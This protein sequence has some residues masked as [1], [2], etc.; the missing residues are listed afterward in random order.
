MTSKFVHERSGD[1]VADDVKEPSSDVQLEYFVVR[2]FCEVHK[3]ALEVLTI[4]DLAEIPGRNLSPSIWCHDHL[5]DCYFLLFGDTWSFVFRLGVFNGDGLFS[6]QKLCCGGVLLCTVGS[7]DMS[8]F[9]ASSELSVVVV[10]A[11]V[12]RSVSLG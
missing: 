12:P 5:E 2:S 9:G 3:V 11:A 1:D 4:E 6:W 7:P 10:C 8:D